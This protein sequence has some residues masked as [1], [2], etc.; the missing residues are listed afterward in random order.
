MRFRDFGC[1]APFVSLDDKDV[2]VS[3]SL[4]NTQSDL[5]VSRHFNKSHIDPWVT[6]PSADSTSEI[7]FFTVWKSYA[8]VGEIILWGFSNNSCFISYWIDRNYT[9]KGIGARA[10][11]LTSEHC[12]EV[13]DL[14]R[15][16]A[17][18]QK[19]NLPSVRLAEK[20]G[21]KRTN[22]TTLDFLTVQGKKVPH[23]LW[24]LDSP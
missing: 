14:D 11:S 10:V 5:Q 17:A 16:Y 8:I 7:H 21:F 22:A 18:I 19:E 2:V 24:T 9:N 23:A 15:I 12:F 6:L 13:L 20:V 3:T 4:S 1:E